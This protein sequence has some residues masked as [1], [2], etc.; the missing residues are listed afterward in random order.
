M[1][2]EILILLLTLILILPLVSSV[3]IDIKENYKPGETIIGNVEGNFLSPLSPENFYFYSDREQIPLIFDSAK[4]QDKYYFYA[5]LPVEER[6]YTL[7]LK[8]IKYYENGRERTGDIEKNFSVSGNVSDFSISPGVLIMRNKSSISVES[9]NSP[10]IVSA[11]FLNSSQQVSV[12]LGQKRKLYFSGAS[13]E[14]KLAEIELSA[15]STTYSVP[16]AIIPSASQPYGNITETDKFRFSKSEYNFSVYEKNK[17]TFKIYLQNLEDKSIRNIKIN[18]SDTLQDTIEISPDKIDELK[19]SDARQIEIAVN[20]KTFKIYRGKISAYSQDYSA[21]SLLIINS[22]E[23]GKPLPLP[24]KEVS[25]IDFGGSICEENEECSGKTEDS[26]E[27]KCCLAECQEKK[28]YTGT[29][30]GIIIL[31]AVLV[32]LFFLYK[33]YKKDRVKPEEILKKSEKKFEERFKSEE[34][35]GGLSKS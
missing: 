8:D 19:E 29:M 7:I 34:I 28:S 13:N 31:V 35:R 18:Y 17:T 2:K 3:N 21:E 26:K 15:L 20:A 6:N 11:K 16:I 24:D 12:P 30:I 23:K 1:K 14:F 4:I 9:R 33:K 32:S 27:G 5:L 25:C 10:L 22:I